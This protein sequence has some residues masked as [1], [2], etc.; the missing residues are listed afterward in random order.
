MFHC[1]P[2]YNEILLA[3]LMVTADVSKTQSYKNHLNSCLA[4]QYHQ[5]ALWCL[6]SVLAWRSV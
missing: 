3:A 2:Q 6:S 4:V 1:E 5:R